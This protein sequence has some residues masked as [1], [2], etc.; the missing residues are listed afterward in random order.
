[1]KMKFNL[2]SIERITVKQMC[3]NGKFHGK[4][5]GGV[6]SHFR[7]CQLVRDCVKTPTGGGWGFLV[8]Q[9]HERVLKILHP[10]RL[11]A[12]ARRDRMPLFLQSLRLRFHSARKLFVQAAVVSDYSPVGCNPLSS[13]PK[14]FF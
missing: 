11:L 13:V 4:F 1:M 5:S 14:L 2:S 6:A 7:A 9:P 12:P 3:V 8:L 10:R